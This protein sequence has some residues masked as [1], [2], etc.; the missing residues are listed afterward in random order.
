MKSTKSNDNS[1]GSATPSTTE[2]KHDL[3]AESMGNVS[4]TR[5]E[6]ESTKVESESVRNIETDSDDLSLEVEPAVKSNDERR[7]WWKESVTQY[8]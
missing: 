5:S 3:S 6:V 8:A 2:L 4:Q 7:D 1:I